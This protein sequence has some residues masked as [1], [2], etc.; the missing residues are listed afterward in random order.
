MENSS[1]YSLQH[2]VFSSAPFQ[3]LGALLGQVT[4]YFISLGKS[5]CEH[6]LL[7]N[8]IEIFFLLIK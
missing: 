5:T 3:N 2:D 6:F 7:K 8:G 1:P 4:I